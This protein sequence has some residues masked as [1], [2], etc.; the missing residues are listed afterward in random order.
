V[1]SSWAEQKNGEAKRWVT[2]QT[3]TAYRAP[4]TECR[5]LFT[6]Y[7]A[8]LAEIHGS[9]EC[10]AL[11]NGPYIFFIYILFC[12]FYVQEEQESGEAKKW[13]ICETMAA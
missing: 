6:E 4:L 3:I 11:S 13:E 8:L 10:T 1:F 9:F 7:T 5:A 12:S 2:L